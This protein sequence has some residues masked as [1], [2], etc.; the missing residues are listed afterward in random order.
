M[1]APSQRAATVGSHVPASLAPAGG[2]TAQTPTGTAPVA[3]VHSRP[4]APQSTRT[5]WPFAQ[6]TATLPSQRR[7]P[8]AASGQLPVAGAHAAEPFSPTPLK[9]RRPNAAQSSDAT[10]PFSQRR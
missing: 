8:V 1:L 2:G 10:R 9:H 6:P 3:L 5:S 7:R 4:A